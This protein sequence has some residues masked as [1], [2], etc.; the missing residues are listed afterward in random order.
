MSGPTELKLV[1]YPYLIGILI[2]VDQLFNALFAGNPDETI[3]SRL[4]RKKR[5]FGGRIPFHRHPLA[6][7][8]DW[9]LERIDPGHSVESIGH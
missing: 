9:F 1:K 4:G 6:S 5:K 8:I 7:A 2:G 3:S